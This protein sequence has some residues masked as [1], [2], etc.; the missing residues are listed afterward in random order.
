MNNWIID[1][2][3]TARFEKSPIIV[4]KSRNQGKLKLYLKLGK[5]VDV[6][7][8]EGYEL[9]PLTEAE[10]KKEGIE[11]SETANQIVFKDFYIE[12]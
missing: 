3:E 4:L 5:K 2:E 11:I 7:G 9:E 6:C 12:E 8:H 1:I 10:M